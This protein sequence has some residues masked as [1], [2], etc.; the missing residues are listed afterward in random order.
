MTVSL[1]SSAHVASLSDEGRADVCGRKASRYFSL[2]ESLR[3]LTADP[4]VWVF[5]RPPW[6]PSGS[7]C[8]AVV[9]ERL[10]AES[11]AN[12]VRGC[13][14]NVFEK[15]FAHSLDFFLLVLLFIAMMFSCQ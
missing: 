14:W 4:F 13:V 3:P 15:K 12:K 7:C 9:Y 1:I 11:D 2:A 6:S 10:R 8:K 5:I